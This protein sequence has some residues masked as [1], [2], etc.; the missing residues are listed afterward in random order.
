MSAPEKTKEPEKP[1]VAKTVTLQRLLKLARPEAVPLG[2]GTLFL[3]I[4]SAASLAYPQ[5][6]AY[7]VDEALGK[8]DL[9]KIN[10]AALV[11]LAVFLVQGVAIAA[12]FILFANAGQR[13]VARLRNQLFEQLMSQEV[14]FFDGQKTGDLTSRLSS[15]LSLIHISEPTRPY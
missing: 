4:G 12:R 13:A 6:V 10:N 14:G 15:D 9:E 5:G 7:I 2:I 1:K 11:M 3:L 8:H